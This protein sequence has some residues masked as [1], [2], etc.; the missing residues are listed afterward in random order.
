VITL[1]IDCKLDMSQPIAS[2]SKFQL[3][4]EKVGNLYEEESS[5]DEKTSDSSDKD[6]TSEGRVER[7]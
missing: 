6:D 4:R 3:P 7:I 5:T 2:T 1:K